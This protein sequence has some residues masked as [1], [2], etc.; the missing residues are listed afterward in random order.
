MRVIRGGKANDT[1]GSS[2]LDTQSEEM[3]FAYSLVDEGFWDRNVVTGEITYDEHCCRIIGYDPGTT[4][5]TVADWESMIHPD[6]KIQVLRSF[7]DH[8]TGRIPS[9]SS[10]HR[11]VK[12][13]GDS[14]WILAHGKVVEVDENS[15]PIRIAGTIRDISQR[16]EAEELHAQGRRI[17]RA[18]MDQIDACASIKDLEGRYL[19]ANTEY[20]KWLKTNETDLVG[21]RTSEFFGPTEAKLIDDH[22]RQVVR[23]KKQLSERRPV[24][25]PDGVERMREL[26]KFPITDAKGNVTGIGSIATARTDRSGS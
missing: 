4:D 6:D 20:Q 5:H 22:D 2:K 16:K 11:L 1:N 18:F 13:S 15:K 17:F 12:A 19:Y 8:L 24:Q 14:V 26:R 23:L 10:E 25:Y 9:Y 7:N 3:H 21:K